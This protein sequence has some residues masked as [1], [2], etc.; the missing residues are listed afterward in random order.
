MGRENRAVPLADDIYDFV[1]RQSR[2]LP[3]FGVHQNLWSRCH[4]NLL[5]GINIHAPACDRWRFLVLG[6]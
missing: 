3:L 1:Q 4:I 2:L 6:Q 5:H